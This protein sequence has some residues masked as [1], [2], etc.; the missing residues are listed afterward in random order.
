VNIYVGNLST[1]TSEAKLRRAF[2]TYGE[3]GK[4][5]IRGHSQD[6]GAFGFCFV[7]MPYDTEASR[8]IREL[9]GSMLDGNSL[10]IKESGVST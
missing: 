2:E 3:V 7:E 4:I 5:T 9:D 10:I 6:R 8:A 1:G